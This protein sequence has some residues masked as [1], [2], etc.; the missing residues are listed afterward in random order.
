[1][2][3][4]GVKTSDFCIKKPKYIIFPEKVRYPEARK[5]CEV[6][7]GSLALPRS[8]D[9]SK[10]ILNVVLEHE[11]ACLG[12][13]ISPEDAAV[14]IGA[15]RFNFTWYEIGDSIAFESIGPPLNYTKV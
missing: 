8:E 14:W 9:E 1:M 10:D 13:N 15:K 11:E 7:G 4:K 12:K 3:I 6:H 5:I 2:K